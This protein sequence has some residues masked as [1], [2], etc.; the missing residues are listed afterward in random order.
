MIDPW[1]SVT[2]N[3]IWEMG[4]HADPFSVCNSPSTSL[5]C[6][7]ILENDTPLISSTYGPTAVSTEL[8]S[9]EF[10]EGLSSGY[11]DDSDSCSDC[12]V[13]SSSDDD[14]DSDWEDVTEDSGAQRFQFA[15]PVAEMPDSVVQSG[16]LPREHIFYKLVSGALEYTDRMTI[17]GE[18][19]TSGTLH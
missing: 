6:H 12:E 5:Q 18:R 16:V 1:A 14:E 19:N 17:Q 13:H 8:L 4:D 11:A 7:P 10:P 15:D 9:A 3:D 2:G